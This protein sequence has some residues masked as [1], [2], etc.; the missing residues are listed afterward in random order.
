[1]TMTSL[2]ADAVIAPLLRDAQT[3][4]GIFGVVMVLGGVMGYL[5]ARSVPSLV[6]GGI[7]GLIFIVS[8]LCIPRGWY[9]WMVVDLILSLLLLGRFAPAILRRKYNPA[10]YVVPLALVGAILA[11]WVLAAVLQP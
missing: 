11:A 1:M 9:T 7:S 10:A 2:L 3:Y 6:A 8:A 4:F 5:K